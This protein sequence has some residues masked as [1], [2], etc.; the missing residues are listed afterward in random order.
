MNNPEPGTIVDNSISNPNYDEFYM[1]SQKTKQGTSVP[2]HYSICYNT[3]S[4]SIDELQEMTYRL[5]Y[6][7][8]NVSGSIRV[9]SLLQYATR[10]STLMGDLTKESKSKEVNIHKILAENTKTLY[11]I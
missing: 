4:I 3:T 10:F 7:Y 2:T 6:T 9:P 1:V 8:F 11:Y 5:C